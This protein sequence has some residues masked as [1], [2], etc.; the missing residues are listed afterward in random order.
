MSI[1]ISHSHSDANL[2]SC[3]Q[4]F[5]ETITSKRIDIHRS[6]KSG[7]IEYGESWIDWINEKVATAKISFILLTPSSFAAK[8]VLWEAGAVSG[9]KRAHTEEIEHKRRVIPIR[10]LIPDRENL[11]PFQ[12]QQ[13]ADGLDAEQIKALSKSVLSDLRDEEIPGDFV[14]NA[15]LE[16]N[17]TS[18][19]FVLDAQQSLRELEIFKRED[20][21]Q[22]WLSRLDKELAADNAR[23]IHSACR[24]I[25]IAFL[26]AGKADEMETPIDFRIHTRL[27]T[28]FRF[29]KDWENTKSQLEL[30]RFLSPRDMLVLRELGRTSLEMGQTQAAI[31]YLDEMKAL[32]TKIFDGD[33]EAF[34]L[35]TRI[36]ITNNDWPG[37][38][39][40]LKKASPMLSKDTYVANMLAIAALKI[41][42]AESAQKYFNKSKTLEKKFGGKSIWSLGNLVNASLG[43][44]DKEEAQFLLNELKTNTEANQNKGSISRYFDD[45]IELQDGFSFNWRNYWP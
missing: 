3:F 11:G 33:P 21:V 40:H 41:E 22:E 16:L 28:G 6:S 19:K 32:D 8:W 30:A 38:L 2:A 7:S 5:L 18:R 35:Y 13:V 17:E 12:S 29:L 39:E 37:A 24:W 27:A 44:Q 34:N 9:V 25:N 26:G 4:N 43:L 31:D 10:F 23:Y 42:G 20:L 36:L 15:L 14:D 45:I 1:F